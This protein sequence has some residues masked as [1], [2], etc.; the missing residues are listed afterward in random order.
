MKSLPLAVQ[1]LWLMQK[2][3]LTN[4]WTYG[5]T[6]KWTGQ[7]LYATHLSMQGHK[8]DITLSKQCF[9]VTSSCCMD[10]PF[11]TVKPFP[12]KP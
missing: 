4:K 8:R 2:F 9:I 11:F 6:D 1:K 7:N 5:Q 12:N 10:C 3:L